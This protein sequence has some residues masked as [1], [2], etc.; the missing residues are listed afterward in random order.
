MEFVRKFLVIP[1]LHFH[2]CKSKLALPLSL[3]S[4]PFVSILVLTPPKKILEVTETL[5]EANCVPSALLHFWCDLELDDYLK[6]ELYEKLSTGAGAA[7]VLVTDKTE[8]YA[9]E[10]GASGSNQSIKPI[11]PTN[12]LPSSK[13]TSSSA[14]GAVPKWF[15]KGK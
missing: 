10:A 9:D 5:I 15:K 6:P 11:V 7:R 12:F 14:T 13:A 8:V 4:I 2:L 1:D 3:W